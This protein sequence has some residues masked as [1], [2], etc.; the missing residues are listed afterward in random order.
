MKNTIAVYSNCRAE[1]DVGSIICIAKATIGVNALCACCNR[2]IITVFMLVACCLC[3][4]TNGY[5]YFFLGSKINILISVAKDI[6]VQMCEA[7][8]P[9]NNV[10]QLA[11]ANFF[12][13][14]LTSQAVEVVEAIAVHQR[15]NLVDEYLVEGFT[16]QATR[17]RNFSQA[18]EPCVDQVEAEITAV[19]EGKCCFSSVSQCFN[20]TVQNHACCQTDNSC[21]LGHIAIERIGGNE[22]A[23]RLWVLH[24]LAEVSP[25]CIAREAQSL[26]E[27]IQ[28]WQPNITTTGN[29]N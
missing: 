3:F 25:A 8:V 20:S 18:A 26:T 5:N 1:R 21:A 4:C 15:F 22:I 14:L 19:Q 16:Q 13:K 17:L 27:I 6:A 24:V 10:L 2:K 9:L 7:A 29:V 23:Q 12:R 28:R 11:V